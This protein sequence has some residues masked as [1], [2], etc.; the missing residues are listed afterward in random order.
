MVVMISR[1]GLVSR[2]ATTAL[3][4]LVTSLVGSTAVA[5]PRPA[6]SPTVSINNVSITEGNSGTALAS[7]T[8]Q[9]KG[10]TSGPT[11][12]AY[13]T[14][15]GT[16]GAPADY[17]VANGVVTFGKGQARTVTVPVNGDL[18]DEPNETFAVNLSGASNVSIADAQGIATIVDDDAAPAISVAD[19]TVGEGNSGTTDAS[20]RVALS[21]AS[22]GD[23][24][25]DYA[26]ADETATSPGDYG[27]GS[28]RVSFAP[29]STAATI[30]VPVAGDS[31]EEPNETFAVN[32][33]G[34]VGASLA[35]GGAKGT[36]VDDET[37]P[38]ISVDDAA[39]A[40]GDAGSTAVSFGVTLSHPSVDTVS[41]GLATADGSAVGPADYLPATEVVSLA[42]GETSKTVAV[43]VAGDAIDEP[44]ESFAINLSEPS[45]GVLA[46][47]Q[48]AGTITD[49][50]AAPTISVG[51]ASVIEGNAGSKSVEV[52]VSL[53]NPSS[54]QVAVGYATVDGTA[55]APGDFEPA[56]GTL[57]F[58]AGDTQK[59]L[60]VSVLGDTSVEPDELLTI[61]AASAENAT[62][63]DATGGV[64]IANDGDR[65]PTSTSVRP[66]KARGKIRV[67]GLLSPARPGRTMAVTLYKKKDGRFV[68]VR[69]KR[70]SLGAGA[71]ANADGTPDSKYSTRF[72][73]PRRTRRCKVVARFTG[74]GDHRPSRAVKTFDC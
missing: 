60:A 72:D 68:K 62:L 67:S 16:A 19:A 23:V 71:D 33:S 20:F 28:G 15:D 18:A 54:H 52:T 26:T 48:A 25:V 24:T 56:N 47:H 40:E 35:D 31:L 69:T 17:L 27:A 64:I 70:P 51:D 43:M 59:T 29:G 37:L 13:A 66:R 32:L 34:P 12:V 6:S 45:N 1:K 44:D 41:V 7:F 49:D 50:D 55:V 73:N 22:A 57:L 10:K 65:W 39:T 74:D 21:H 46:D 4:A 3:V 9:L 53:S 11:T 36:I 42:P 5:A 58:N 63:G 8:V 30:V 61:D 14:A 38:A 2:T